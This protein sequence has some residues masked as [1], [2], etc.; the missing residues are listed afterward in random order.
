MDS[1]RP[2]AVLVKHVA[3]AVFVLPAVAAILE[4]GL[5]LALETRVSEAALARAESVRPSR[6]LRINQDNNPTARTV[7]PARSQPAWAAMSGA[8]IT[9]SAT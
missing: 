3:L 8:T 2:V 6:S 1:A 5:A 4:L 9:T 7:A